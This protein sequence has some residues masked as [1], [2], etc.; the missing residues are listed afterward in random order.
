MVYEERQ[1][2]SYRPVYETE[3][4]G[5]AIPSRP[6]METSEREERYRVLRP[7]YETQ[8]R[9]ASYDRVRDVVETSERDAYSVCRPVVETQ[10]R[11]DRYMV[12]RPVME[13]A[14]R[15]EFSTV[16]EPVVTYRPTMVDQ[17]GFVD[18]Q[19]V[20][21]GHSHCCLR[22]L[23]GG[24]ST[25]PC[26]GATTVRAGLAWVTVQNPA[27]VEVDASAAQHRLPADSADQLRAAHR[28]PQSAGAGLPLHR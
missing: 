13:T 1:V 7:V 20:H 9:D 26:T 16:C 15:D 21:P 28:E 19:T 17:G 5:T 14:K 6:V 12:R 10:E 4:R 27:R 11:E 23:H 2:T 24:C 3:A 25:D 8:Y 18:Q 22:W